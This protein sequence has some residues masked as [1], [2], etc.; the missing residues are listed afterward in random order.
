MNVKDVPTPAG[1]HLWKPGNPS[2]DIPSV[3]L[4]NLSIPILPFAF[5]KLAFLSIL[6]VSNHLPVTYFLGL[7]FLTST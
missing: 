5:K 3:C 6:L 1:F 4:G 7:T 2:V